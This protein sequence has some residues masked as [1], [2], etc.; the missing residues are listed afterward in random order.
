MFQGRRLLIATK[1]KKER[2]IA[3]IFERELG[4]KCFVLKDFDTDQ[5]GTFTGEFQ[6]K[7][8][9]L[10]TARLKCLSAMELANCDMAVSN[11]G[12][13]GPH[14]YMFFAPSDDEWVCFIDKK[15][16]LEIFERELTTQ[17]NFHGSEIGSLEE[18]SEFI[19]LT[20]FPSHGLIMKKSQHDCSD[21][22]KTIKNRKK[23]LALFSDRMA[24]YG[25]VYLETD[26]RA[27]NNPTRMRAIERA[28]LKLVKKIKSCC[29]KCEN[30]G[31]SITNSIRGLRCAV[32]NSPTNGVLNY[33]QSCAK[34]G[35]EQVQN[36]PHGKHKED[37]MYCDVCNP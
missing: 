2:V 8:D 28:T 10:T 20:K 6:R 36:F 30:P 32:C 21:I 23:L 18:L 24:K 26:M 1:H 5:F 35:F 16:G 7:S 13:F 34:C 11:E 29:P 27:F 14:P 22:I 25:T 9:P 31:F 17:T 3:P 19:A 33:I 37:P 4:V 15:N 12:S